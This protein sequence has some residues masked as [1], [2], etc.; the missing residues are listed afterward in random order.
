MTFKT[1]EADTVVGELQ[2]IE[3]L[4]EYV[5]KDGRRQTDEPDDYKAERE[6]LADKRK[7]LF[8]KAAAMG[9]EP[10]AKALASLVVK[11]DWERVYLW[12]NR[13]DVFSLVE[14]VTV[15]I[16]FPDPMPS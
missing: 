10:D 13:H 7:R 8:A 2:R 15:G 3:P 16:T 1:L 11:S 4:F 5:H 14:P 12:D 9:S 6:K